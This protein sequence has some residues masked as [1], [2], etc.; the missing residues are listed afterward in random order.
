MKHFTFTII[1][2]MLFSG[3]HAQNTSFFKAANSFFSTY[4]TDGQVDY[5]GLK[6]EPG[7]LNKLVGMIKSEP[8]TKGNEEK[9]FLINAYNILAIKMVVDNYPMEGPLKVDGFFDKE[10]FDVQGDRTS[11]NGIEKKQLYPNYPDP[12]L[13]LVLVCAAEGCPKLASFAY[14]PDGLDEQLDKQ[15]KVVVNNKQFT[16]TDDKTGQL[17]LSQIFEWYEKDFGGKKGV[18]EFVLKYYTGIVK[19]KEAYGHY[20]YDWSLNKR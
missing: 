11:L 20:E 4:V 3:T 10:V 9:A 7:Q 14:M 12:R 13:H 2:L 18:I 19:D 5:A 8:R 16:R 6:K 1:A 15:S 17:H